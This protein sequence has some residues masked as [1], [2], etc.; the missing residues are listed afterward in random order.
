MNLGVAFP[1][2]ILIED[3]GS[4]N[5]TYGEPSDSI[6]SLEREFHQ[7]HQHIKLLVQ[8]KARLLRQIHK[9]KMAGDTGDLGQSLLINRWKDIVIRY[10]YASELET[11]IVDASRFPIFNILPNEI[12]LQIFSYLDAKNLC[13][14]VMRTCTL[15]CAIALD[16]SLWRP[17]YYLNWGDHGVH[18]VYS[19]GVREDEGHDLLNWR[20]LFTRQSCTENNW[21]RGRYEVNTLEGHKGAVRCM[22]FSGNTL[23]TGSADKTIKIW[24]MD[25]GKCIETLHDNKWTRC[26][27]YD[28]ASSTLVTTGMDSTQAKIWNLT[29]NTAVHVLEVQRGWITSLQMSL[30]VIV[31]GS[32]DGMIRVWDMATASAAN[33]QPCTAFNSG[34][35]SLRSLC[36][37]GDILMSAGIERNLLLWDLRVRPTTT[38]VVSVEG[39]AHGNYCAMFDSHSHMVASGSNGVVAVGDLRRTNAPPLSIL[40]GHTDVVSCLQFAGHKL[41]TGSMDQTVRVWDTSSMQCA[42]TLHGH[43]SWVWDLQFDPDKIVTVSGD[44]MVKMWEFN[45]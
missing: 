6:Q 13:R 12:I 21:W 4:S 35:D 18:F 17:L 22:H 28:S 10:L 41:V 24:S 7:V 25:D 19:S 27:R 38:P 29:T 33:Q 5:G 37:V 9:H 44:K 23:V 16:E 11:D 8:R 42:Q 45:R 30:P 14:I 3:D 34:H 43:E 1:G 2:I 39:A 26:L 32:L 15:F 40:K 31:T 20:A 36:L